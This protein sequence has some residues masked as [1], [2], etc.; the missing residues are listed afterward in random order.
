M[1]FRSVSPLTLSASWGRPKKLL[2][3]P[4]RVPLTEV[5]GPFASHEANTSCLVQPVPA[6][7]SFE[8]VR[9]TSGPHIMPAA[10]VQSIEEGTS[11]SPARLGQAGLGDSRRVGGSW[12]GPCRACRTGKSP[13][14]RR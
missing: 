13:Q 5:V 9:G 14:V 4:Q 10:V 12:R 2:Y 8:I 11:T 1:R 7:N 6:E 3:L